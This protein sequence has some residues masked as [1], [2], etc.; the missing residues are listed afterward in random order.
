[1]IG[2]LR[3]RRSLVP[4]CALVCAVVAG[5]VG[6]AAPQ[7]AGEARLP[8]RPV[9]DGLP[10]AVRR[11]MDE[12][13]AAALTRPG[14]ASAI[15]AVAMALHAHEQSSLASEWYAAASL[16]APLEAR[17]I[18]LRGVAEVALGRHDT[19]AAL[20]RRALAIDARYLPA[21]T[22]LAEA[23]FR[24]GNYHEGRVEYARLAEDHP[25]LAV[26][27]F[28]LGQIAAAT[29]DDAEAVR[30]Y[31]RAVALV[32]EFG[33]A[34]YALAL[35]YR[36]LGD[37]MLAERH[38]AAYRTWRHHAPAPADPWLDA[39]REL[40][41]TARE[42]IAQA[43]TLADQGRLD[44]SIAW[45]RRALEQDP[46]AAQAHINLIS[47]YGR[48]GRPEDATR[49]Y[50]AALALN[51]NSADAHYNYGVLLVSLN[52]PVDALAAF[53]RAAALNPLHAAAH[54]NVGS[55]LLKGGDVAG[56]ERSYGLSLD[57]E[58]GHRGARH[59]LARLL[60]SQGRHGEALGHL[61]RLAADHPDSPVD[62]LS[63]A[64]AYAQV[65]EHQLARQSAERGLSAAIA[66][67]DD[68][69]AATIRRLLDTTLR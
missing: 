51:A 30:R 20:F 41:S 17:Y 19:A 10:P 63:L 14:D 18:Y 4:A 55:L 50:Q 57:A 52:R 29:G 44:E 6:R 15:A 3:V 27:Q 23:L 5:V 45:H 39:V 40:R 36:A 46:G 25:D 47:L 61:R 60:Q 2:E 8:A 49:H 33:A 16:R 53:N 43:V 64:R 67:G 1:M 38:L 32:P 42:T 65:G 48:T 68:A 28:G 24:A 62:L 54:Y 35:A 69:T 12:A 22:R 13:L 34:Q 9:T 21:R 26:A 31:L 59:N 58:P 66:R 11:L 56:A 7:D 37:R